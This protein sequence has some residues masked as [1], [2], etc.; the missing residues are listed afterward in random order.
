MNDRPFMLGS[1]LIAYFSGFERKIYRLR[2]KTNITNC[3]NKVL[4]ELG[5]TTNFRK[6][7]FVK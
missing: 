4:T 5:D 2:K 1:M 7:V 6:D 3:Y